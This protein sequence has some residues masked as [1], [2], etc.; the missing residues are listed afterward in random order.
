[1]F[2]VSLKRILLTLNEVVY[3]CPLCPIDWRCWVQLYPYWFSTCWICHI[4]QRNVSLQQSKWIYLF[5]LSV[6]SVFA[7]SYYKVCWSYFKLLH[8]QINLNSESLSIEY[9]LVSAGDHIRKRRKEL[10]DSGND[11]AVY[12]HLRDLLYLF[13]IYSMCPETNLPVPFSVTNSSVLLFL[14]EISLKN[15]SWINE[16]GLGRA[17][18]QK[19]RL[20]RFKERC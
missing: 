14:T 15:T 16:W 9:G 12:I 11:K 2:H 20:E 13:W 18:D 6:L 4:W 1:M 19:E 10:I 7:F 5:L 3:R 8:S 17:L